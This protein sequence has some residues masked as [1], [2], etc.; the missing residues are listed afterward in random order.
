MPSPPCPPC[1]DEVRTSGPQPPGPRITPPVQSRAVP[2]AL[3]RSRASASSRR[4]R[5]RRAAVLLR[6]SSRQSSQRVRPGFAGLPQ[7]RRHIPN[8]TSSLPRSRSRARCFSRHSRQ[9]TVSPSAGWP[10]VTHRP[11]T[12]SSRC[13]LALRLW[14]RMRPATPFAVEVLPR[15]GKR[16]LGQPQR[17]APPATGAEGPGQ[18]P[19]GLEV[20]DV[21][22]AGLPFFPGAAELLPPALAHVLA[23]GGP[24][25]LALLGGARLARSAAAGAAGCLLALAIGGVGRVPLPLSR[26]LHGSVVGIAVANSRPAARADIGRARAAR[27][28]RTR[29]VPAL[30]AR[31][32]P[33]PS[34]FPEPLPAGAH[35]LARPLAM[36]LL[37]IRG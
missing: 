20:R 27:L 3:P 7:F 24:A 18:V 5:S 2:R 28:R 19:R 35:V 10:Q 32:I 13:I 4:R 36:P 31:G 34:L 17:A 8:A 25:S 9:S 12:R 26:P 11:S 6:A 14:P 15:G 30:P 16:G 1:G 21:G 29:H 22:R 37:S 23:H 33:R